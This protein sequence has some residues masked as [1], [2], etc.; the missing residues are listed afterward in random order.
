MRHR[1]GVVLAVALPAMAL[2]ALGLA[3][4]HSASSR[5]D[6][7]EGAGF[8]GRQACWLA[9]GGLVF[10]ALA[11]TDYR[12]LARWAYAVYVT[13]LAAL[14]AVGPLGSSIH[15]A[16][17]WIEMGAYNLQPSEPAKLAVAMVLAR[18]L[19]YREPPGRARALVVPFLLAALP[20]GLVLR[21][22]DLG[23]AMVFV[24]VLVST[25]YLAGAR[26][27]HLAGAV[28]LAAAALPAVWTWGLRDYQRRRFLAF[29]DPEGPD[30]YLREGYQIVQ[31]RI[32]VGHGGTW[33]TGYGTGTQTQW[34]FLPERHTDF[35]FAVLG[36]EWGFAGVCLVL[37][38][39][40][41][42]LAGCAQVALSTREPFG[43]LVV[44]GV[45]V[46]VA[47]Q[48]VINTGMTVGLMPVTGLT[49]PLVSYGGS[50]VLTTCAAL[51]LVA[52]VGRHPGV[53][54]GPA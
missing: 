31:S 1:W 7:G 53:L 49:L 19:M 21:Q 38:L 41:L 12:H 29:L 15:G 37:L 20:M 40:A 8:A 26:A 36:E 50:S 47:T 54:E 32:A 25:L 24:P 22:P 6:T 44:G 9:A 48:A 51:G 2:A 5:A 46:L 35:I 33:G 42:L 34:N 27:A 17:R 10:A 28:A 18:Y 4:I 11:W 39:L 52:S 13:S 43:R 16:Q 45:L 3:F 23:T 30:Y 14:L